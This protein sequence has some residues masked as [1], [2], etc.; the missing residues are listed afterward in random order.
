[1]RYSMTESEKIASDIL[2]EFL[3]IGLHTV[4]YV[5]SLYP[6]SIFVGRKLYGIPVHCSIHPQLNTFITE[7]MKGI[8]V[9]L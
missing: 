3:E 5:R 2:L 7:C 8:Q 6:E 1:M 9:L 4:L